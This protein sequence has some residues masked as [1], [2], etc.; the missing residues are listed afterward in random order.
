MAQCCQKHR[1][2]LAIRGGKSRISV[3]WDRRYGL[4]RDRREADEEEQRKH[5]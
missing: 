1:E 5:V 4:D 2:N 3:C